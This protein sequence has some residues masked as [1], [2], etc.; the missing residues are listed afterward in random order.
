MYGY[1]EFKLGY[2]KYLK[3]ISIRVK[4]LF[5]P[6][7]L[8][9]NAMGVCSFLNAFLWETDLWVKLDDFGM[10]STKSGREICIKTKKKIC[11]PEDKDSNWLNIDFSRNCPIFHIFTII[12]FWKGIIWIFQTNC[13]Y[14]INFMAVAWE[15]GMPTQHKVVTCLFFIFENKNPTT[16]STTFQWF[17]IV[18]TP[19][20][21]KSMTQLG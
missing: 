11:C 20:F 8:E 13:F 21:A 17:F 5:E 6:L 10:K 12:F 14:P 7:D 3:L 2:I 19:F 1:L 4:E 16:T 9:R 15:P 18:F